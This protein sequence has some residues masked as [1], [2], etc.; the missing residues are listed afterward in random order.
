MLLDVLLQLLLRFSNCIIYFRNYHLLGLGSVV[1]VVVVVIVVVVVVAM[2][3]NYRL[4]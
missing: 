3:Q 1:V 2:K 4:T